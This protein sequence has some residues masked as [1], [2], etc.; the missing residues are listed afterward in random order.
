[1]H[2]TEGEHSM[3]KT[4]GILVAFTLLI[5]GLVLIGQE[6]PR[7]RG[8]A[9]PPQPMSFFVTNVGKGDGANYGGVAGADAYCQSLAAAAGRGSGNLHAFLSTQGPR[10]G[11][12]RD[13]DRARPRYHTR[14][15]RNRANVRGLPRRN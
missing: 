10:A 1:M 14:R 3:N 2:L 13:P 4:N 5:G 12:A 9:A 15:E 7:G 6:A 11:H 8:Q